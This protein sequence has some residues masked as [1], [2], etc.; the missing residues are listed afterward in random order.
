MVGGFVWV[1]VERR[2][3][4]VPRLNWVGGVI[5]HAQTVRLCLPSVRG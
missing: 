5:S 3:S 4:V 2:S 1:A